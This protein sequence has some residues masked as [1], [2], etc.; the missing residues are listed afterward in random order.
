[1][2]TLAVLLRPYNQSKVARHIGVSRDRVNRWAAGQAYPEVQHL[3]RLAEI[4]RVD[5]STLT[6]IIAASAAAVA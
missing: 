5:V 2:T 3:P 4:L 6:E 1:M